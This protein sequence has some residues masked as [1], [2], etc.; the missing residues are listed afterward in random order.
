MQLARFA[1]LACLVGLG[2]SLS[3]A[4]LV[5]DFELIDALPGEGGGPSDGDDDDTPGVAG[6]GSGDVDAGGMPAANTGGHGTEA[7]V[8][9][10]EGEGEG[11][12]GAGSDPDPGNLIPPDHYPATSACQGTTALLCDDFESGGLAPSVWQ[13]FNS[14][15]VVDDG[16]QVP[17]GA[18]LMNTNYEKMVPKI[19][20]PSAGTVSFWVNVGPSDQALI[21]WDEGAGAFTSFH[22]EHDVYRFRH[23][24]PITVAPS[25]LAQALGVIRD[26]WAC[27]ELR[28]DDTRIATRVMH[29]DGVLYDYPSFDAEP[30]LD[31]DEEWLTTLGSMPQ[32]G[33]RAFWFGEMGAEILFDDIMVT[34]GFDGASVCDHYLNDG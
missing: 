4:C 3:A 18:H 5:K 23:E 11:G 24:Q 14:G 2:A 22:V 21:S 15:I 30:T 31:R 17:S 33:G 32:L 25:D 7:P 13:T 19:T 1:R 9:G 6:H 29:F 26:S 8:G 34:E 10:N 12:G 16:V 20:F 28:I 27:V